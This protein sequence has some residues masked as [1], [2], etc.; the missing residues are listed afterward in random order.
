VKGDGKLAKL[1]DIG[2]SDATSG[3]GVHPTNVFL[4][5]ILESLLQM[6]FVGIT[7]NCKNVRTILINIPYY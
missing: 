2:T 5:C 7:L 4:I 6:K 3:I 1:G